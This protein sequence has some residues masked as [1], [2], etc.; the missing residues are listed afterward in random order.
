MKQFYET[1]KDSEL[2]ATAGRQIEDTTIL[3]TA[4]REIDLKQ[5]LLEE[6]RWSHHLGI[7]SRCKSQ[8]EREYIIKVIIQEHYSVRE[9]ERQ[10]ASG[11][12]ASDQKHP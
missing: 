9:L 4:L 12:S 6:L 7:I 10:I 3:S 11:L 5:T 2:L 8:E 1:C